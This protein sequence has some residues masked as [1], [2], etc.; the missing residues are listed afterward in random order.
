MNSERSQQIDEI[1][2]AALDLTSEQR[3][4]YLDQACAGDHDLRAEVESLISSYEQAGS[5]IEQPAIE[6]DAFVVAGPMTS[7]MAGESIGHYQIIEPLGSG[8]MGEVYLA[9]DTRMDRKVALKLLPQYF[10]ED[11]ERVRRF[12]QEARAALALNH[13]NIVAIYEI[14]QVDGKHFI[15]TEFIEGETLR[16]RMSQ[17]PL[18]LGES[19]DIA[20]QVAGGLTAAHE[21]GIIHRD[22]KP[23]NVMLRRDGYAKVLDF[24]LAKLTERPAITAD[25]QA[26]TR[27]N[28]KTQPG[29]V[30]GTAN[31]MSPEQARGLKVDVRTDIWSLGV[32][33]YEMIAGRVPFEGE[34]PSDVISLILQKEAPPLARCAPETPAELQRIVDKSLTKNRDERYQTVKDL[35]IDLRR[36]NKRLDFEDEL[37][38]SVSPELSSVGTVAAG[39]HTSAVT[40]TASRGTAHTASTAQY[41]VGQIKRHKVVAIVALA[42]I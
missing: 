29:I 13:P 19:I 39:G 40:L 6:V 34:T 3:A 35:L 23:E 15:V 10:T 11:H 8:G 30:M 41:L 2:Q 9:S 17:G 38:R 24:G 42:A 21:A 25:T 37:Q 1:F 36:L 16:Q 20:S 22:I 27:V 4:A 32:V 5:F 12:Q 7:V 18:K 14:G 33:L 26:P 31:Y 28:V